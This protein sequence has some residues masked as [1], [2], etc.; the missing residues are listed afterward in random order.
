MSGKVS[1]NMMFRLKNLSEQE[2]FKSLE[3]TK[4]KESVLNC[5]MNLIE[6][7][8]KLEE[9]KKNEFDFNQFINSCDNLDDSN[10][11]TV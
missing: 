11:I 7:K 1:T 10:F 8:N 3:S 2:Q 9:K 6:N 4:D 5:I